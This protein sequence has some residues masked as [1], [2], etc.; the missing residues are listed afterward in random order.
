MIITFYDSQDDPEA[1]MYNRIVHHMAETPLNH[2]GLVVR[3][4]DVRKPLPPMKELGDVRGLLYWTY[5]DYGHPAAEFLPW[6]NKLLDRKIR[7][8]L[9]SVPPALNAEN[10]APDLS[11]LAD[12]FWR[13]FGVR[14]SGKWVRIT[15]DMTLTRN[16]PHMLDFERRMEGVL[17]PYDAAMVDPAIG[18]VSHL[19]AQRPH[20]PDTRSTL[21]ATMPTGGYVAG[22]YTHFSQENA[23]FSQW[24][25]NPFDFFRAAFQTDELPKPDATTINGRRIFYSHIDGDGW[26]NLSEIRKYS[27]DATFSSEVILKEIVQKYPDLPVTI[28]PVVGDLDPDWYGGEKAQRVAREIFR[29]PNVEA[30]SHTF[31]HPLDWGFFEDPDPRK[32]EPFLDQYPPRKGRVGGHLM[33]KLGLEK[34]NLPSVDTAQWKKLIAKAEAKQGAADAKYLMEEAQKTIRKNY[35]RPRAYAVKPFDLN[36]EVGGAKRFIERFLPP[37]KRVEVLQWSGNTSPFLEAMRLTEQEKM[38]NING[39]DTRFDREYPSIAWVSPVGRQVGPYTQIYAS[40][41]NE[42][43]YTDLWTDRFFGFKHLVRTLHNTEIPRRLKPF[44]VYYHMYSGQ[45]LSSLNAVKRNL[46]YAREQ[47]VIPVTTSHFAHIGGG[48]YSSQFERLTPHTWR[49]RN[50]GQLCTIRFDRSAFQK[51]D[52]ARSKGVIGQRH[53]YGSLY[54]MLDTSKEEALIALK[55]AE[56]SGKRPTANRLYLLDSRWRVWN[57]QEDGRG[58]ARFFASGFGKGAMTWRVPESSRRFQV[59]MESLDGKLLS[60]AT[61]EANANG[62]ITLALPANAIEPVNITFWRL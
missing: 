58:G 34:R 26:R 59:S 40:N 35:K 10:L 24:W 19:D 3:H 54:V 1:Y 18:A 5:S 61:V 45:K 21:V 22:G 23:Q 62:A 37:G 2:L 46:D 55:E 48:F 38:A 16:T 60:N 49:V 17:P 20:L 12:N 14:P 43:T 25:L 28:G 57:F 36:L 51:V 50:H 56:F 11:A 31:S 44:N 4:L 53:Q 39:G 33:E 32:E 15:Y 52:F 47:G 30:G 42:N 27:R 13:R 41:S 6:I 7:V 9:L 8:V 29:E